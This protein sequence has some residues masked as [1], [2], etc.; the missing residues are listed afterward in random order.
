MKVLNL[1]T[2]RGQSQKKSV[3]NKLKRLQESINA[4]PEL[5]DLFIDLSNFIEHE[6]LILIDTYPGEDLFLKVEEVEKLLGL[7]RPT[8]NALLDD[9]KIRGFKTEKGHRRFSKKSVLSY[10]EKLLVASSAKDKFYEETK[11]G[12]W[13]L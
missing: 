1:K 4:R 5:V 10:L 8:C 6:R 3:S 9:G 13:E 11:A 7:S 12:D 2:S